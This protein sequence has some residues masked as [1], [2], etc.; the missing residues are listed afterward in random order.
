MRKI[1]K[2]TKL[3]VKAKIQ[4]DDGE[5]K[6][7]K[8][9]IDTEAEVNL[10]NPKWVEENKF[11]RA[12]HP[13]KL[14]VANSHLLQGG[15]R[16]TEF[17]VI[18]RGIDIDSKRP[19]DISIPTQAYDGDVVC[20]LILSYSWLAENDVLVNARRHGLLFQEPGRMLWISGMIRACKEN[21]K[22]VAWSTNQS[23]P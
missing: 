11:K 1:P 10:I 18:L 13:V 9:L 15:S 16:E 20:D 2:N 5:T 17:S 12:Q 7:L 14:G 6:E 21:E 23:E 8:L 3:L 4:W 22:N 19:I